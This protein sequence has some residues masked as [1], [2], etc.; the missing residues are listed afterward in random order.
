[1]W[2]EWLHRVRWISVATL[3][4]AAGLAIY[5]LDGLR[6]EVT[7]RDFFPQSDPDY[8]FYRDIQESL[9]SA[10]DLLRIA[11]PAEGGIYRKSFLETLRDVTVTLDSLNGVRKAS[12]IATLHKPIGAPFGIQSIPFVRLTDDHDLKVDSVRIA[13]DFPFTR[14]YVTPDGSAAVIVVQ[15][16]DSLGQQDTAQLIERISKT[17]ARHF[18]GRC[19]LGG[20]RYLETNYARM[21]RESL[22]SVAGYSVLFILV[23]L[24][25]LFRSP[26]AVLYPIAVI[27]LA[28]LLFLG[29]MVLIDRSLGI[30]ASLFPTLILIVGVSDVTHLL[31]RYDATLTETG[32]RSTALHRALKEIG[33][34]LLLTSGTTAIGL[35]T[36]VQSNMVALRQ[37][38]YDAAVAVLI[39]FAVTI[40]LAPAML[41]RGRDPG[42]PILRPA[43]RRAMDSVGSKMNSLSS[44]HGKLVIAISSAITL[45]SII[46]LTRIDTNS[47]LGFRFSGN[48][49]LADDIAFFERRLGGIRSLQLAVFAK[50]DST[51]NR[52]AVLS[53]IRR[54]HH[55]LAADTLFT[56]VVSP[57]TFYQG[58]RRV[59]K[60]Y[61]ADGTDLPAS[62][63]ELRRYEVRSTA[64]ERNIPF[65]LVDS[66]RKVGLI[67]AS[68][69]DMGRHDA[70][71]VAARVDAWIND[72]L[73]MRVV[74]FRQTGASYLI[75]RGHQ[76]RINNMF[77]GLGI[78]ILAIAI[79]MGLILKDIRIVAVA[80]LVNLLPL[81]WAG[82]LMGWFGVELRGTTTA[83]F[84]IGFVIAVDDT[85]HILSAYAYRIRSGLPADL[86]IRQAVLQTGRGVVLTSLVLFGGFIV[87]TAASFWD[88]YIFGWLVSILLLLALMADLLLLP[89]LL[90]RMKS[91]ATRTN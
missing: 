47:R 60:P 84:A 65:R 23:M 9:G 32:D 29:Y 83:I 36:F 67:G 28:G 81:V 4:V 22:I 7:F 26:I 38:G 37:F 48:A 58:L 85:L 63:A 33:L 78:A 27:T 25:A 3:L 59:W 68:M 87:L 2:I 74:D 41:E 16:E 91:N 56:S 15:P 90:R 40:L 51:L 86:A 54:L 80:M 72:H 45:F 39:T 57:V 75:D 14:P 30:M 53:E 13:R 50:Q 1:M 21:S 10:D 77:V 24:F 89:V 61:S 44:N 19:H 17:C 20:L 5:S 42:R 79:I 66:S 11:I 18:S 8:Q 88:I 69:P 82:G 6:T 34:V 12:S 62:D 55:H 76:H 70:A 31:S 71:K 52:L 73:D 64:L 35:L 43:L 49:K 46:G